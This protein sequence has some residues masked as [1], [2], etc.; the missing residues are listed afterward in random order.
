MPGMLD[1]LT[2]PPLASQ[3]DGVSPV[4]PGP[5]PQ[6]IPGDSSPDQ[7]SPDLPP[8]PGLMSRIGGFLSLPGYAARNALMGNFTG[9]GRNLVD[10]AGDIP[11]A[12]PG[13][14]GFIPSLSTQQDKPSTA[15]VIG[16][17]SPGPIRG[18]TNFVG[19]TLTDP[20]SYIPGSVVTKG[21]GAAGNAIGAGMS[22][23]DKIAPDAASAL[24]SAYYGTKSTLGYLT[25]ET[26]E[27]RLALQRA[28][29][30]K[31][32]AA[33][34]ADQANLALPGGTDES[35][36]NEA[37]QILEN[38]TKDPSG[39]YQEIVPGSQVPNAQRQLG[40]T[41]AARNE[42][43][44]L[45]A[46]EP[47][48]PG[49]YELQRRVELPQ[50]P[51]Q[52][53]A[54]GVQGVAGATP[55]I[56][57][58]AQRTLE[59]YANKGFAPAATQ[60]PSAVDRM[61]GATKGVV[62]D[63]IDYPHEAFTPEGMAPED[64]GQITKGKP[65]PINELQ[66]VPAGE[67]QFPTKVTY[68]EMGVTGQQV[69]KNSVPLN[70]AAMPATKVEQQA[71]AK[72]ASTD[73]F[74]GAPTFKNVTPAE[75]VPVSPNNIDSVNAL[76]GGKAAEVAQMAAKDAPPSA[77]T[78]VTKEQQ[79]ALIDERLQARVAA[80]AMTQDRANVVRAYLDGY[81][82]LTR[83]LWK[84]G[85]KKGIFKNPM[86]EDVER[87]APVDYSPR[88]YLDS[89]SPQERAMLDSDERFQQNFFGNVPSAIKGRTVGH[90]KDLV[91][92]LN[93][94]AAKG[95]QM[96]TDAGM[97]MARRAQ[98][99]GSLSGQASLAK[100]LLKGDFG[101]GAK[102][103]SLASEGTRKAVNDIIDT[104]EKQYPEQA[105]LMRY[106]F[107]GMG[108]RNA[109]MQALNTM[110]AP[111]KRSAVY[112][113]LIPQAGHITRNI[114]SHPFQ[115]GFQGHGTLAVNQALRTPA[116]IWHAMKIGL[117]KS[118]GWDMPYDALEQKMNVVDAAIR[119][120]KGSDLNAI[121]GLRAQGDEASA[122]ALKWGVGQGFVSQEVMLD[123]LGKQSWTRRAMSAIG[124]GKR[125]QNHVMNMMDAPEEAFRG[126]EQ[127]ARFGA[128]HDNY[129]KY[130]KQGMAPDVAGQKA[131]KDVSDSLYDYNAYTPG[132]RTL[133]TLIPFAAFQTNAIRQ[134]TGAMLRNPWLATAV[135]Q[136]TQQDPNA[137]KYP[138]MEGKTNIPLGLDE[139]GNPSYISQIGLPMEA[140]QT[141]PNPSAGLRDFGR[142]IESGI[143]GSSNP[144]L[145]TAYSTISGRDSYFG[146]PFGSYSNIPGFGNQGALGR[147][148]N[149]AE[150]TGLI[151]PFTSPL[152][153][154]QHL[155]DERHDLGTRL[156]N[157][158]TGA[159]IVSVDPQR[160]EQQA[161]SNA[162]ATDPAIS[163]YIRFQAAPGDTAGA[164]L[165]KRMS[166]ANA[167][168][169]EE[170]KAS[171]ANAKKPDT[172]GSPSPAKP[173]NQ[174]F[175]KR[176]L[177]QATKSKKELEKTQSSPAGALP[178]Q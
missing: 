131:A 12:V 154:F 92:F 19:D 134:T 85:V 48:G 142:Q 90:G 104:M 111:F 30:A 96:E 169:A 170:K 115:Y 32:S 8:D 106:A 78:M 69:G 39:A 159:N 68:P 62:R 37:G 152:T 29:A 143:V 59:S 49:T 72:I 124:V 150:S 42:P 61:L 23:L 109:V 44:P 35:I 117:H 43:P 103:E 93:S 4:P 108:P 153:Q 100:D 63:P 57:D 138:Y 95:V 16:G 172:E 65:T 135:G 58:A 41:L 66:D 20:L 64:L 52:D 1:G 88:K 17:M 174:Q 173:I 165:I 84:D 176:P 98:Q 80:G 74:T 87:Y 128:F 77:Q 121:A 83:N 162:L 107:N 177:A 123:K 70:E 45:S 144:L 18:L 178:L 163:Q 161:L 101:A 105:K 79:M 34:A 51:P 10:F 140:M 102:Y 86:G 53:Q 91:D 2:L 158:L 67:M 31:Q 47:P 147:A 137:P 148:F 3:G 15:D 171:V 122:Q 156:L 168:A 50:V 126:E 164:N 56:A 36:R 145:K 73:P 89:V 114:L 33:N 132:N 21:L 54:L 136:A 139:K 55:G 141:I 7:D 175:P 160:A 40:E 151:Q 76:Q 9:A 99:Q 113:I 167:K 116:T 75:R 133:R 157:S 82:D 27:G 60:A 94:D 127:Y 5:P 129:A 26:A 6:P 119:N 22:G 28:Q 110:A 149:E 46:A 13:V 112:G 25:P 146:T 81:V 155:T 24:R 130:T 97:N 71:G 38:Y 166:Q 125:M 118:F 11:S 120:S 14:G